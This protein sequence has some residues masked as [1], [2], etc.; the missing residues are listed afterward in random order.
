[1]EDA[2]FTLHKWHSNVPK[3]QEPEQVS[4]D[5]EPTYAKQQL[6][7]PQGG[8]SSILGLSW[9]KERDTLSIPIPVEKATKTKRVCLAKLAKIYDP[10]RCF[11]PVSHQGKFLYRAI[12]DMKST[13]DTELASDIA[14][15]WNKCDAALPYIIEVPRSVPPRTGKR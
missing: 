10:L 13:W 9:N 7:C 6:R 12:C 5:E 2:C 14:K 1:M 11:S 15:L 4:A 3:L 8:F